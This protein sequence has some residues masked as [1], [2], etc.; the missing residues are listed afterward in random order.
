MSFCYPPYP[1][2]RL[3]AAASQAER[4]GRG[5]L[6]RLGTGGVLTLARRRMAAR[7]A[8]A[9]KP[10]AWVSGSAGAPLLYLPA[11]AWDYR[12]QRPQ[13]L[14]RAV[15]A[16]GHP[17]LYVEGFLRT[18][19]QPGRQLLAASP[20]VS[21]LRLRVPGRPDPYRDVLSAAAAERLAE[22][23]VA[24]LR[25]RPYCVLVQLPFWAA[26]G[27]ALAAALGVP[28]V[29]DRIDLHAGFPGVPARIADAERELAARADLVVATAQSLADDVAG[30][31]RRLLVVRNAVDLSVF[32][33][34]V[35]QAAQPAPSPTTPAPAP[36][37]AYVGALGPWFHSAA[38]RAAAERHPEWRIR[39]AGEVEDPEVAA[40]GRLPNV[41]L[42]GEIPFRDVPAFLSAADVA[43]VPFRDLP[44][45]RAVDPVKLYEALALGLPVVARRLPETARWGEPLVFLYDTADDFTGQVERALAAP[46]RDLAAERRQAA[47]GESWDERARE[48]LAAVAGLQAR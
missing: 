42:L 19:L 35:Y 31:A 27:H 21:R 14:A 11:V 41:E 20:G 34:A 47:A 18:R 15:A 23:V 22:V 5:L 10:A 26:L 6:R 39:L 45:T 24:G 36:C 40:L 38:L 2:D 8:A 12:F 33:A 7:A 17:V 4:L 32:Q 28:L 44:L 37:I 16:A 29:Y 13:Q 48:L 46:A 43:L 1:P 3:L 25:E 9:E 30:Q